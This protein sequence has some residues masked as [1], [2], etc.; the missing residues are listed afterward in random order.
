MDAFNDFTIFFIYASYSE[1]DI[2][3][4]KNPSKK[5]KKSKLERISQPETNH[6]LW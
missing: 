1:V 2:K 6:R 5:F 3:V 4:L